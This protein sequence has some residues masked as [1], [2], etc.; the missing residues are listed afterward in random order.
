MAGVVDMRIRWSPPGPVT[1]SCR[2]AKSAVVGR[3][4]DL[5]EAR[6]TSKPRPPPRSTDTAWRRGRSA[7]TPRRALGDL[8]KASPEGRADAASRLRGLAAQAAGMIRPANPF[9]SA[10]PPVIPMKGG[11]L[12][13]PRHR[14]LLSAGQRLA[15]LTPSRLPR[16]RS[17][18]PAMDSTHRN[19]GTSGPAVAA[20][21]HAAHHPTPVAHAP[22]GL[23]Q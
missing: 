7:A 13:A 19:R 9:W 1:A 6:L 17:Q 18:L 10:A 22:A 16:H 5:I 8:A 11:E 2:A 15:M 20:G 23:R 21:A 12:A 4:S 14:G 3:R